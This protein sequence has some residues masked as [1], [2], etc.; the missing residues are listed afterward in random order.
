VQSYPETG[1]DALYLTD[2]ETG[3][4]IVYITMENTGGEFNVDGA[5]EAVSSPG[6]IESY[7]Q[8]SSEAEVVLA[9]TGSD[10]L[11]VMYLDSSGAAPVVVILEAHVVD[12]D[13]IVFVELRADAADIDADL[14]DSVAGDIAVNEEA[15][16]RLLPVGDILDE[17]P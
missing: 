14:L 17:L 7:L 5:L 4:A 9:D 8:L 16:L 10:S 15:G 1:V 2:T 12:D 6:Y 11:A 3:N 13:S